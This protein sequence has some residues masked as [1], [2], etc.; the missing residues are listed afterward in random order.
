[1][2]HVVTNGS[3]QH[4]VALPDRIPNGEAF[5]LAI[6]GEVFNARWYKTRGVLCLT[7]GN[8]VEQ[9]LRIR[10]TEITRSDGEV[11]S[12]VKLEAYGSQAMHLF[13]VAIH[14]DI[15]GQDARSLQKNQK[16]QI[17]KSQI[18]GRIIKLQVK[19]GDTVNPG[20]VVMIIE[21]MKME[22]RVFT[23][24]KAKVTAVLVKEGDSVQ[25]GKVLVKLSTDGIS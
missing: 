14:P 20:D 3:I 12:Q 10:R 7:A 16:D 17:I 11:N 24:V 18:T 9:F 25:T 6:A 15:P 21:A 23:Q 4:K 8:G 1:M 13:T 5:P 22:N 2:R 19:V